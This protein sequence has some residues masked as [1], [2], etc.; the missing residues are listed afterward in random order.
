MYEST[1]FLPLRMPGWPKTAW[2][3]SDI[4][5]SSVFDGVLD[6]FETPRVD[7]CFFLPVEALFELWQRPNFNTLKVRKM[8]HWPYAAPPCH[9]WLESYGSQLQ[10]GTKLS[11]F[12][13]SYKPSEFC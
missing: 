12:E 11:R 9:T 7:N 8:Y 3:L 5:S 4:Y 6:L 1:M 2:Y 10:F 13:A